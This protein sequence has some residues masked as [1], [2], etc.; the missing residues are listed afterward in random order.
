MRLDIIVLTI[1]RGELLFLRDGVED[2]PR[3]DGWNRRSMGAPR[4]LYRYRDTRVNVDVNI[5]LAHQSLVG[6]SPSALTR[7]EH[8]TRIPT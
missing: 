3:R 4:T 5:F 8:D 1:H 7:E 2:E 6:A